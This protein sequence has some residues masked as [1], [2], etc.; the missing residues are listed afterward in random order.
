MADVKSSACGTEPKT[1]YRYLKDRFG[2][3]WHYAVH[4]YWSVII[5]NIMLA[6]FLLHIYVLVSLIVLFWV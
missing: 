3:D 6:M 2:P 4:N 1:F 5:N